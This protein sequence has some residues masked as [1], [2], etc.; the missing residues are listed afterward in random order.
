MTEP[1]PNDQSGVL[2]KF[3]GDFIVIVLGVLVALTAE[4]WW[5]GREQRQTERELREDMIAEFRANIRILQDDLARNDE[6]R[7]RM[8]FLDELDDAELQALSSEYLTE[9]LDG[10]PEWAGFDPEMGST[11]ALVES[12]NIGAIADREFRLRLA[13]WAGLLE[14]KRRFTLQAVEFQIHQFYPA[15][16]RINADLV[17]TDA[18]RREARMMLRA[19]LLLQRFVIENQRRLLVAAEDILAYLQV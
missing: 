11:Q 9:R 3:A 15:N 1:L 12:G 10:F 17:W 8:G 16:T 5:S 2:R 4:S 6:A 19:L 18:E 13:G 7:A 14:E